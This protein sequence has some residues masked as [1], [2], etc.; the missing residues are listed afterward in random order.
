MGKFYFTTS[1]LCSL[2]LCAF[3][4][5]AQYSG[6]AFQ[7]NTPQVGVT[8][9]VPVKI[10]LENYDALSSDPNGDGANFSDNTD[11][12]PA[13]GVGT[14]NDRTAGG[15]SGGNSLRPNSDVDI[16]AA[17]SGHVITSV[18]GQEYTVY[19]INVVTAGVY[20]MGVNYRHFGSSKDIKVY[21]HNTDGTGK[22][23]LYDSV[24]DGGLPQGDYTTTDNLGSFTLPAGPLLIRFRKLDAGPRFD[25][26]TLTLDEAMPLDLLGFSAR[27]DHKYNTLAWTTANEENVSHFAVERSGE[28]EQWQEIGQVVSKLQPSTANYEFLD[29]APTNTAYYRL[30]MV[31]TDG[32]FSYSP[33]QSVAREATEQIEIFPNPSSGLFTLRFAG[34]EAEQLPFAVYDAA[35]RNVLSGTLTSNTAN[36]VQL[37]SGWYTVVVR[38]AGEI[39]IQRVVVR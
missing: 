2:L 12:I 19:T 15:F 8:V 13:G 37:N 6:V 33:V 16:E 27:P 30:R 24:P 36:E 29:E 5:R 7:G 3:P 39:K 20:H 31:D 1:V 26:F 34:A 11:D 21:S 35:G 10:E 18:Q 22:T 17:G 14:Y 28:G 9:G 4:V 23:L 32:S 38:Q 25:F